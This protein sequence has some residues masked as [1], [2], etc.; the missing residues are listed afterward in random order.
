MGTKIYSRSV[1]FRDAEQTAWA[2]DFELREID[3]ERTNR[4]TLQKYHETQEVSFTGN[5]PGSCGQIIDD[6]SPRTDGQKKLR[7]LWNRWHLCDMTGGTDKQEE[8]LHSPQYKADYD[9]F[10]ETFGGY[11]KEMRTQFDDIAWRV[12]QKVFQYDVVDEPWVRKIVAE[13]MR[14]NPI[15]YII[16]DGEKKR[17]YDDTHD[18]T[19]YYVRA[20]FLAMKGLYNDRGHFYGKGW[21]YEPIPA[22]MKQIVDSLFDK[23]EAE[24]AALTESLTPVFDMGAE[25]FEATPTIISQ[26][27]TL[28]NCGETEARRFLALGMFLG[29]TFGDLNNTFEELEAESNL[30]CADGVEYYVGTEEELQA[31]AEGR[32]EDGDYDDLWREAVRNEQT[33]LGL[34]DWLKQVLDLNGWCSVLNSWDGNYTDFQI[35]NE[36]ICVS[37]T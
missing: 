3:S 37:R 11:T 7:D 8:Y 25:G 10:V 35:G 22:D 20:L 27:M 14:G 4:V 29:C 32:L 12:L 26:V 5:G 23:I 16:G 13:S 15:V 34:R 19:D 6:F 17:Y 21:L 1:R 18:R 9:K 2:V 31:V 36:W 24:E 33:E 28:R 30:Y